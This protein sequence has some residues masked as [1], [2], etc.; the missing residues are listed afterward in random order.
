M[1]EVCHVVTSLEIL[2]Q[3]RSVR[4]SIVVKEKPSV[5]SPFFCGVSSL[6]HP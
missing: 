6:Q 5:G 2:D 1:L 3:N 4:W